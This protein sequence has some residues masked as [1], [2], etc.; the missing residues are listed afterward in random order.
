MQDFLTRMKEIAKSERKTIV[1]TEGEDKRVIQAAHQIVEE[2]LVNLIILGDDNVMPVEGATMINPRTNE[3]H[4][5]YAVELQKL[6]EKK[7]MT[8]DQARELVNDPIYFGTMML[9]MGDVDGLV[10]GA[11]HST[12][13]TLR[14]ALQ[15]LKIAP[16]AKIVS[17]FMVMCIKDCKYGN[18]NFIFSDI[19]LN[20]YPTPDELSEI[21]ISTA[22]SWKELMATEPHIAMLSYSTYGSARSDQ[23]AIVQE[24]TRLVHKKAPSL[25]CDGELQTDAALDA[26]VGFLKAPGSPVA[27]NADVLIFPNLDAGNIGYKLVQRLGVAE[28][29]GPLLQGIAKPVNDLSRGCSASDIVAVVAIT[30]V[31]A[32]LKH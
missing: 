3:K 17:C 27:G 1:L 15:I 14:P 32:I 20:Q 10:S 31:Q 24:A 25:I 4:E 21:A 13:N 12:A 29:Y 18:G 7:G 11:C 6:R 2:D 28:A 8:I 9:K 26:T 30:A 19:G 5:E 23:V 22:E 16:D